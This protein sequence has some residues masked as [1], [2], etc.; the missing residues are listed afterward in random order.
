MAI[1]YEAEKTEDGIRNFMECNWDFHDFRVE[2]A[3]FFP[4]KRLLEVFLKYDELEGSVVLRFTGVKDFHVQNH[5]WFD[6]D[7]MG[8]RTILLD[9]GGLFWCSREDLDGK[10]AMK[11]DSDWVE[12]DRILW[13]VT[14]AQGMPD[15]MPAGKFD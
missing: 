8:A 9:D 15:E 2:R 13:A 1:W 12:A 14:N 3:T 7:I 11:A 5:N 4:L 6:C 10:E